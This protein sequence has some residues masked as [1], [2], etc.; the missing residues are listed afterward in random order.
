MSRELILTPYEHGYLA[1]LDH[2][3]NKGPLSNTNSEIDIPHILLSSLTM[4]G[5]DNISSM[6]TFPDS[7]TNLIRK[8]TSKTSSKKWA[9]IFAKSKSTFEVF[10]AKENNKKVISS[11][12]ALQHRTSQLLFSLKTNSGII[13]FTDF[14]EI[15]E[16]EMLPLE[17][18]LP[19]DILFKS[20]QTKS[21][22]LPIIKYE[23]DKK[24]VRRFLRI[25]ESKEFQNY[26][27]AQAEIEQ[28]V[29]LTNKTIK[30]I[31]LAGKDIYKKN[32]AHIEIRENAIK[33][34][35]LTGKVVEL[36]FGKLPGILT[37]FSSSLLGDYLK[38]SKSIPIYNCEPIV[39]KI[40]MESLKMKVLNYLK[41][42]E[43][44]GQSD[45]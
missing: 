22:N 36:F 4:C 43:K 10:T 8:I 7:K 3:F 37:D 32:I 14:S 26:K 12:D 29:N 38:L 5:V 42:K 45:T 15:K 16:K 20:I 33:A 18:V 19:L 2:L 40:R 28:N 35:P 17:L 1:A 34:L 23:T 9:E 21:A 41:D 31:E 39:D 6:G 44:N 30:A 24:D 27:E 11:I 13:S 25:L